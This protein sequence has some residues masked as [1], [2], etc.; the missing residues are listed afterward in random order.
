V[1]S[2]PIFYKRIILFTLEGS[3]LVELSDFDNEILGA[4]QGFSYGKEIKSDPCLHLAFQEDDVVNIKLLVN[5]RIGGVLGG[6][7]GTVIAVK[8][9]DAANKIHYDLE[10]PVAVLESF[11]VCKN[12][13]DGIKLCNAIDKG[14]ESLLRKGILE[15]DEDTGF[16]R[17]NS[18]DPN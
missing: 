8:K 11:Y 4:V 7:P 9:N 13:V 12:D 14:I 1:V 15:L 5:N 16:S 18:K 6:Y 3:G 10:R 2:R 17:F